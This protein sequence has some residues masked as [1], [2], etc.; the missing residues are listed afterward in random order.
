MKTP[1][2]FCVHLKHHSLSITYLSSCR[3]PFIFC[4]CPCSF[5]LLILTQTC[6]SLCSRHSWRCTLCLIFW[7]LPPLSLLFSNTGHIIIAC[8]IFL[9]VCTSRLTLTSINCVSCSMSLRGQGWSRVYYTFNNILKM[10]TW[11]SKTLLLFVKYLAI[12]DKKVPNKTIKHQQV[13]KFWGTESVCNRKHVWRQTVL[14]S[15]KLRNVEETLTT[16]LSVL[17]YWCHQSLLIHL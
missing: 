15:E 2:C 16:S 10:N 8:H 11:M 3:S 13:T 12:P 9:V 4:G 7:R 5:F 17:L 1:M 6:P 14:T